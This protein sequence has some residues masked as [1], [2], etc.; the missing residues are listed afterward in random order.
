MIGSEQIQDGTYFIPRSGSCISIYSMTHY[1]DG[2]T[3][4]R[5]RDEHVDG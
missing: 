5:S 4:F 1:Q 2:F 3:I